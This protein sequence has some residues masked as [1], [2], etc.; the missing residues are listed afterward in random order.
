MLGL[1]PN[2]PGQRLDGWQVLAWPISIYFLADV[3]HDI[4]NYIASAN[5]WSNQ[6]KITVGLGSNQDTPSPS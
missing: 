3:D 1:H 5:I 6:K 4:G 2:L